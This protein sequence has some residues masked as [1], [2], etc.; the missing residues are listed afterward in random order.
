MRVKRHGRWR[1]P[2]R[3]RAAVVVLASCGYGGNRPRVPHPPSARSG[4]HRVGAGSVA[5]ASLFRFND[6]SV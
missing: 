3:V 6:L 1:A 2:S 4:W 5:L